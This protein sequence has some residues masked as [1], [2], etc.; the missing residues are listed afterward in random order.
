VTGRIVAAGIAAALVVF[1]A[2]AGDAFKGAV[3][4][5]V[6]A[7]HH[8]AATPLPGVITLHTAWG[9]VVCKLRAARYSCETPQVTDPPQVPPALYTRAK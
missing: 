3:S 9:T 7:V 6:S 1:A 2:Q 8:P 5:E 4:A